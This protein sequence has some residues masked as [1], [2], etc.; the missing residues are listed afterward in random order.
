MPS[1]LG[2][3]FYPCGFPLPSDKVIFHFNGAPVSVE[4]MKLKYLEGL[5]SEEEQRLVKEYV[6]YYACAPC[7][8]LRFDNKIQE[9][10][11]KT[12]MELDNI[13]D[14]LLDAGIDPL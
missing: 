5:A 8:E 3:P 7:F 12:E 1:I 9:Q 14:L 4:E 13:L 11:F 10:Y 6:V 2:T